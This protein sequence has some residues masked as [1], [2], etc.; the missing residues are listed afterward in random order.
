M[1]SSLDRDDYNFYTTLVMELV[2]AEFEGDIGDYGLSIVMEARVIAV[3]NGIGDYEFWGTRGYHTDIVKELE[4]S[5]YIEEVTLIDEDGND[6]EIT[7]EEKT[8]IDQWIK[9]NSSVIEEKILEAA[10]IDC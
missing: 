6:V 2:S 9:Q 7:E 4:S 3:D 8:L 1:C 5:P 10:T